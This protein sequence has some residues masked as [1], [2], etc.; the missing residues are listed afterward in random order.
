METQQQSLPSIDVIIPCYNAENTLLRA[1]ESV[2]KQQYVQHLYLVDDGSTDNTWYIIS[3]LAEAIPKVKAL[4]M[5]QNSGVAAARN[6]AAL[7]S[8]AD[9]IAFLDADDAY[10]DNALAA[11][12]L[13]FAR[14][15]ELALVR[16]SLT[17]V[18]LDPKYHPYAG[19]GLEEAWKTLQ[20]TVGGN[21]IFRR[22]IFLAAG[23][24]PTDELFKIY[25]GEDAALGIAFT[26]A[27]VVGVL[28]E[29]KVPGV[30][31]YCRPGMHAERLLNASLFGERDPHIVS[32]VPQAEA[33]TAKIVA[34]LNQLKTVL[35]QE[36]LGIIPLYVEY[37]T[38]NAE[39]NTTTDESSAPSPI[40]D[41]TDEKYQ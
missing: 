35:N 38:T 12:I 36:N 5:P 4:Q 6:W 24:F 15:N 40:A 27:A 14:F 20:M 41:T 37:K 7:H 16:L 10:Q 25:G 29:D 8:S 28:F 34:Q 30:L 33:V 11:P 17:A 39:E 22:S 18:D 23:G 2:L 13:S 31:H 21:M 19:K 3:Q 26:E 1:V 32:L 9:L